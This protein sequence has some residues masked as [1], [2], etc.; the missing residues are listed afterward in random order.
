[1][2]D[3]DLNTLSLGKLK[4][5]QRQITKT[6]AGYEERRKAEA[7]SKVDQVAR[8]LGYSLD[9]LVQIAPKRKRTPL[10][11]R[12]RHPE[13]PE[14]TWSGRGRRPGWILDALAAGKSLD[15]LAI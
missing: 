5:L 11:P 4:E 10:P 9:E 6:I 12:Y 7:H 1:M 8:E 2:T 15:D 14:I 13:Q 3:I